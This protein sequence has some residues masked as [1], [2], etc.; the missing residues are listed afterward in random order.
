MNI[1]FFKYPFGNI[2]IILICATEE[3]KKNM[4]KIKLKGG[5]TGRAKKVFKRILEQASINKEQEGSKNPEYMWICDEVKKEKYL[6][7]K[8]GFLNSLTENLSKWYKSYYERTND[9][10]AGIFLLRMLHFL[11]HV[12]FEKKYME[13]ELR[14]GSV[15]M[16]ISYSIFIVLVKDNRFSEIRDILVYLLERGAISVNIPWDDYVYLSEAKYQLLNNKIEYIFSLDTP[17]ILDTKTKYIKEKNAY[18]FL[19]SL[20]K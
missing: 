20:M 10:E 2:K 7:K 15:Q 12:Q 18:M 17:E 4:K 9:I 5:V 6:Q 8:L 16:E 13:H 19:Q 1:F 14:T 3:M 11:Y